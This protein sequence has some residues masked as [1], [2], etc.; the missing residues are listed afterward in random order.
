MRRSS[1]SDI[2]AEVT[3]QLADTKI[4]EVRLDVTIGTL[5]DRSLGWLVKAYHDINNSELI[6][7]VCVT[8]QTSASNI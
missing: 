1:H 4:K 7:K 8:H 3:A 5:R 6:K 2:V